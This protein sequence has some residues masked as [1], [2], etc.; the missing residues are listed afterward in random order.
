MPDCF[1]SYSSSDER[2]ARTMAGLLAA[3][4]V[5]VFLACISIQPGAHWS[6][7]TLRNLQESPWVVFLAS[8][9]AAASSYVNQELG[10]AL[11]MGKKIIPIVWDMPPSEL[12]GWMNQIQAIDLRERV[13]P[14]IPIEI[15]EQIS[16][17]IKADKLPGELIVGALL[18]GLIWLSNKF[19]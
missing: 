15:I 1:I 12:P 7:E 14:D 2:L 19:K 4:D 9:E 13:W 3:R 6:E 11:G 18:F 17:A 8:R 10:V 16:M 5:S